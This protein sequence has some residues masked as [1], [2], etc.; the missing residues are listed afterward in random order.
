[1][2][3]EDEELGRD[4]LEQLHEEI[5]ADFDMGDT[6]RTQLIP[7]AVGWCVGLGGCPLV[8]VCVCV[9]CMR[10]NVTMCVGVWVCVCENISSGLA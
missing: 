6:I 8:C 7:H 5:E 4:E 1:M 2:P 9:W 10:V 3:G